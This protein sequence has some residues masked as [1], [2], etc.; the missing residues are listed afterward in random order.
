[1]SLCLWAALPVS[2]TR[3]KQP[4]GHRFL[5]LT[6]LTR[7]ASRRVPRATCVASHVSEVGGGLGALGAGA[8]QGRGDPCG[9]LERLGS[10][11]SRARGTRGTRKRFGGDFGSEGGGSYF[12]ELRVWGILFIWACES[13]SSGLQCQRVG[14]ASDFHTK[15]NMQAGR[16]PD[17]K[18]LKGILVT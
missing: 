10:P 4:S 16:F 6:R 3:R 1:M 13:L 9:G 15:S 12:F 18:I 11:A 7:P 8:V 14:G 17:E 5:A 2:S